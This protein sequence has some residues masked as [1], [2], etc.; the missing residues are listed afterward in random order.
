M[1]QRLVLVAFLLGL[2]GAM[3]GRQTLGGPAPAGSTAAPVMASPDEIVRRVVEASGADYTGDC[4]GTHSP[5]D[6]GK[7]CSTLIAE[8]DG[9]RAYL[10]G[11][12]FSEYDTWVFVRPAGLGWCL[13]GVVPLDFFATADAA[14][15]PEPAASCLPIPG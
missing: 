5:E 1:M 15:W 10:T 11:R 9:I 14:P 8:R 7:V 6:V 2:A 4:A 13:A 12:T 3:A